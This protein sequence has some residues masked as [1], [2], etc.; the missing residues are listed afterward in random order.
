MGQ[1]E[2]VHGTVHAGASGRP[3]G[4]RGQVGGRGAGQVLAPSHEVAE[5]LV[6]AATDVVGDRAGHA[7]DG[8]TGRGGHRTTVVPLDSADSQ[9]KYTRPTASSFIVGIDEGGTM[10]EPVLPGGTSQAGAEPTRPIPPVP[11]SGP[12][13]PAVRSARRTALCV[14][15]G[16]TAATAQGARPVP[17]GDIDHR[18][19]DRA[20]RGRVPRRTPGARTPGRGA[21]R[22]GT[23]AG[24]P[25][26][27]PRGAGRGALRTPA[28]AR[29]AQAH[30]GR[31]AGA[32]VGGQR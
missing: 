12:P 14:S 20:H 8:V 17:A 21:A 26:R 29:A 1:V 4:E 24:L 32:R 25:P 9:R 23:G 30:D 22:R 27:G 16:P 11:P 7:G 5:L 13:V 2:P 31:S 19:P 28:R 3:G 18:W 6:T 10:T 15:W